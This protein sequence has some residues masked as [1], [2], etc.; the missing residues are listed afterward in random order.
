MSH[1][2]HFE[3]EDLP[4]VAEAFQIKDDAPLLAVIAQF[5]SRQVNQIVDVLF[6]IQQIIEQFN[7]VPFV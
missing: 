3:E 1:P 4:I 6:P 2:L 7:E 5:L